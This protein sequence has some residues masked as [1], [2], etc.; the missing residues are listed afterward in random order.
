MYN[1]DRKIQSEKTGLY[2]SIRY[3]KPPPTFILLLPTFN[4]TYKNIRPLMLLLI[5]KN[6]MYYG[7][8]GY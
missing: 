6:C 7:C 1:N 4:L 5:I 2:F 8:T 3:L